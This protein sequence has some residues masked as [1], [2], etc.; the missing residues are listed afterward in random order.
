MVATKAIRLHLIFFFFLPFAGRHLLAD[1][2]GY[3]VCFRS[4]TNGYLK[5]NEF[6][7]IRSL[8]RLTVWLRLQSGIFPCLSSSLSLSPVY[9]DALSFLMPSLFPF[10]PPPPFAFCSQPSR[11]PSLQP[12]PDCIPAPPPHHHCHPN[13]RFAS[14]LSLCLRHPHPSPPRTSSHQ[15]SPPPY[16]SRFPHPPLPSPGPQ[17]E[18]PPLQSASRYDESLSRHDELKLESEV[19]PH[20]S[21]Q[22]NASVSSPPHISSDSLSN[23]SCFHETHPLANGHLLCLS[24]PK[25]NGSRSCPWQSPTLLSQSSPN[26]SSLPCCTSN[27]CPYTLQN[28][29]PNSNSDLKPL[30]LPSFHPACRTNPSTQLQPASDPQLRHPAVLSYERQPPCSPMTLPRKERFF[31]APPSCTRSHTN[32]SSPSPEQSLPFTTHLP[33]CPIPSHPRS[34]CRPSKAGGFLFKVQQSSSFLT[35]KGLHQKKLQHSGFAL[36]RC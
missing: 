6:R 17:P 20:V 9:C 28:I 16:T 13:Q 27:V 34:L 31:P 2:N 5:K 3:A 14:Q 10:F 18:S 26:L 1:I 4:V 32:H 23:G 11:H 35:F 19:N 7:E 24:Q 30:L 12:S 15:P 21:P 25:P 33:P 29:H 8:F 36:T 22:S